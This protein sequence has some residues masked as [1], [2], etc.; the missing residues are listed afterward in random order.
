[1]NIKTLP[2]IPLLSF[3][4]SIFCYSCFAGTLSEN[5]KSIKIDS[6]L[7]ELES[8]YSRYLGVYAIDTNTGKTIGHRSL[9]RFPFQS[10]VKF[11]AAAALLNKTKSTPISN[12]KIQLTK[13]DIIQWSPISSLYLTKPVKLATLAEAAVSYS[14]NTAF[15]VLVRELGGIKKINQ[16][17]NR[18]GN[19]SFNL[20][21]DE[22]NLNSDPNNIADSSTPKDIAMSIQKILLGNILPKLSRSN[23]ITW[24]RNN[25]T[26]YKR[27]RAGVPLGWAVA[28][29]TGTGSYGVA[30]DIG[31]VWTPPCKPIILSIFT[32]GE[33][34]TDK[35][36]DKLIAE[37]T[38]TVLTAFAKS[39]TCLT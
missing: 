38:S 18:T 31:I 19:N 29:K 6:K 2:I 35:P 21:H 7:K 15:N 30:N 13:K 27:I 5:S 8:R 12:K 34:L 4:I 24:L 33:K 11:F 14:D 32:R 36:I 9:E 20:K 25:T 23:L 26:G 28:D 1:M 39:D 10:T 16:F 22:V 37:A 3:I 17:L